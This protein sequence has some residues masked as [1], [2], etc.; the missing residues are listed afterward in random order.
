M[1]AFSKAAVMLA[2]C[3][4]CLAGT[5]ASTKA[6]D[7]VNRAVEAMGGEIALRQ[8]RTIVIT[9]KARHW[10]PGSSVI[11]GGEPKCTGDSAIVSWW[12]CRV[13]SY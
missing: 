8:V 12:P 1:R 5:G 4:H 2:L 9:Q 11:A 7:T 10:E 6:L 13:R 3:L